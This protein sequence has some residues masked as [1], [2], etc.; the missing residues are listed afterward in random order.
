MP[1]EPARNSPAISGPAM[2]MQIRWPAPNNSQNLAQE[3]ARDSWAGNGPLKKINEYAPRAGPEFPGHQWASNV[4]ANPMASSKQ[5]TKSG[6]R[7]GP[8]FLGR[9]WAS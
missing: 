5:L 9:Q 2:S 3:P 6:P 1:H 4:D 8:G 7:A